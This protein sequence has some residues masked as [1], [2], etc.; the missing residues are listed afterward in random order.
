MIGRLR[1][2]HALRGLLVGWFLVPL[3]PLAL[4]AFADRWPFPDRLPDEFGFDGLRT[5]LASGAGHAALMSTVLGLAVAAVAT[6]VGALAARALA[7]G[8]VVAPRL[9]QAIILAPLV[10]P[11][12]AVALGLDV[13]VLRLRIPGTA[14]VV[15][16]LAVAALPY[17]TTVMRLAFGAYDMAYEEEART[18]GASRW[19]VAVRIRLPLLAPA[20]SGAAFLAFLVAWSDYV[21][22]LLIGGG[23]LITLPILVASFAAGTGNESVVAVLSSGAILPPLILLIVVARFRGR[24]EVAR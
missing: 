10:L 13:V 7:T 3:V 9:V 6:P 22:T 23:R 12:F 24:R 8:R 16:I 19:T 5:A 1:P 17:T 21:V 15:G 2:G 14:A 11:A 18:L 4:W 20:I